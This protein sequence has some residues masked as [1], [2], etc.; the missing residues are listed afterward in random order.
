M[1]SDKKP[2]FGSVFLCLA[3]LGGGL[4]NKKRNYFITEV[5]YG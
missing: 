3:F 5:H 1:M 4:Y 2:T